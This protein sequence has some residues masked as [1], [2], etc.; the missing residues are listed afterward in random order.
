MWR[1]LHVHS[2]PRRP[3]DATPLFQD[4]EKGKLGVLPTHP[5]PTLCQQLKL[6]LR[7]AVIR[8][9]ENQDAG[10]GQKPLSFESME[11]IPDIDSEETSKSAAID[12]IS[13]GVSLSGS[14][15]SDKVTS[16]DDVI[17][18]EITINQEVK[19]DFVNS[20]VHGD[21]VTETVDVFPIKDDK[22]D[23]DEKTQEISCAD[24]TSVEATASNA[25]NVVAQA[26]EEG[27]THS[28]SFALRPTEAKS[29]PRE[30]TDSNIEAD[31]VTESQD[32]QENKLKVKSKTKKVKK[33]LSKDSR[34]SDSSVSSKKKD[35]SSKTRIKS[36]FAPGSFEY[37]EERLRGLM[38]SGWIEERK[39]VE[40]L[41]GYRD[42]VEVDDWEVEM[43]QILMCVIRSIPG[44]LEGKKWIN[45]TPPS[46][47]EP[48][49]CLW[50]LLPTPPSPG[51]YW[52][53]VT[54]VS[55]HPQFGLRVMLRIIR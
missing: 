37:I 14:P 54:G 42:I 20:V 55:L 2:R 13:N 36:K 40:N 51:H 16:A 31:K 32:L 12:M 24:D 15:G 19:E 34:D 45:I 7:V 10:A 47:K 6:D 44:V 43:N 4:G 5:L 17:E 30:E 3:Y 49:Y 48:C 41:A 39:W 52:F 28:I 27:I 21:E 38:F 35:K 25:N 46:A 8:Y 11:D 26:T 9:M 29:S 1:V 22:S 50:T 33:A 18:N 53:S 23:E